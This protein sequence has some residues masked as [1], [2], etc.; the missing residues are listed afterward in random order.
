VNVS[1]VCAS[2]YSQHIPRKVLLSKLE[3]PVNLEFL[4]FEKHLSS[5]RSIALRVAKFDDESKLSWLHLS[6]VQSEYNMNFF[7]AG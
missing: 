2:H 5:G 4:S 7:D 3:N 6:C 1:F